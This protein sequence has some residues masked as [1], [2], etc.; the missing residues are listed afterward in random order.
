MSE[1]LLLSDEEVAVLRGLIEDTQMKGRTMTWG[2]IF[3][4]DT[5]SSSTSQRSIRRCFAG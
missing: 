4:P 2:Y 5:L 3:T 1:G